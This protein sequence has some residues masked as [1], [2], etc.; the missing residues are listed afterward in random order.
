MSYFSDQ[1]YLLNLEREE[2][3][4]AFKKQS[5]TLSI[6]E[7]RNQGLLWYPIAM[8]GS[9]IGK[10]DYLT[11]EIERTTHQELVHNFRFGKTV[12]LF[13]NYDAAQN[14]IEGIITYVFS[15]TIK[16]NLRVDELPEWCKNGKLGLELLFDN[17]S[18]QEMEQALI[19]AQNLRQEN[20]LIQV[21]LG[22]ESASFKDQSQIYQSDKLNK[23]Q[24]QAVQKILSTNELAIVHGPPG[25]GK[26]TTLVEAIM[27][28]QQEKQ[29]I[30]VTAPSNTAVDLL[31]AKLADRGLN[32]V[33][34]GNPVR[35]SNQ[36][37]ELTLDAKMEAHKYYKEV[38]QFKKQASDFRNMA[39][40][41]KRN[42][43]KAEREQRN[44]L[45]NEAQKIL[46]QADQTEK[47]ILDDILDQ[48]DIIIATLVGANH[49][50][51]KD[52]KYKVAIIDE[53]GQ[54]L[55]PACWIPILKADKVVFAGD[56][57]Q[58]SPTVKSKKA[59]QGGLRK[60][61]MEKSV[62]LHPESVVLLEEQYRMNEGIMKFPSAVFYQD[63]LKAHS[64]VA[65]KTLFDGDA[66][67]EFIDTAG[68]SF[69]EKINGTSISNPDEASFLLKHLSLLLSNLKAKTT[70]INSIAVILP[71][72]EQVELIQELLPSYE[73]L[74][75]ADI[76]VNT[77]DSFQ[78]QER[79]I[80][81]IGLTRSN[82]TYTIGF[83][84]DIR[85]MN[86]AIT[87]ARKKLVVVGDSATL[88]KHQFYSSF[89]N[90]AE[91]QGG[92][93]SAWEFLHIDS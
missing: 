38:K 33:R 47:F 52:R 15:N 31:S 59:E 5:L 21:L 20:R 60:T 44:A 64:T 26:T 57:Q 91:Q 76:T 55:E 2:D 6:S 45:F 83:L 36:L 74:S 41:Y 35:V 10:G 37:L 88:S 87:R 84:D 69:E 14:R 51:V 18:Y 72:R 40:K 82:S 12:A 30:L 1:L 78:G 53:A 90:Y 58:L 85:R 11:I 28:L 50:T 49:Y 71:Y 23:S 27:A 3:F 24:Q 48:A 79:D 4:L 13:S 81:Y 25:T 34:I 9:E 93:K 54:A 86:V 16:V 92:Y 29:Q 68:C 39:H 8:R 77:V 75:K 73:D 67:F 46:K 19:Q 32:V 62:E 89:I 22:S 66:P 56:H 42:F 43:G 63:S 7:K 17:N 80:V 70:D 65:R 61:L